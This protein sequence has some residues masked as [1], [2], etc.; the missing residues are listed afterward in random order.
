MGIL[1]TIID[2]FAEPGICGLVNLGNTCY[3]NA[4]LQCLRSIPCIAQYYWSKSLSHYL[5]Y[6]TFV[7]FLENNNFLMSKKE[8][9]EKN[10]EEIEKIEEGVQKGEEETGEAEEINKKEDDKQNEEESKKTKNTPDMKTMIRVSSSFMICT[11]YSVHFRG[12]LVQDLLH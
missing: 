1:C 5:L 7:L 4:G 12:T 6:N 3:M 11:S 10:D 2:F 8:E 9:V